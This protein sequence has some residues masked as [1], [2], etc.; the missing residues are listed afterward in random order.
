MNR[1]PTTQKRLNASAPTN[2]APVVDM[3]QKIVDFQFENIK[4]V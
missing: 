1:V 2:C 3:P 4:T